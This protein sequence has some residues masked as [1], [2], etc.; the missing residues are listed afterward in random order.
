MFVIGGPLSRRRFGPSIWSGPS[1][2]QWLVRLARRSVPG[3][4]QRP[5]RPVDDI[6]E[7][8]DCAPST[9]R[10]RLHRA[11]SALAKCFGV[12]EDMAK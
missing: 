9:E 5:D 12:R 4:W 2:R 11:L 7:I 10:V 1:T 3:P 6:A 8:L